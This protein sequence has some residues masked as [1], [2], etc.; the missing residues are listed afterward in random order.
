MSSYLKNHHQLIRTA[1]D[2]FDHDFFRENRIIFGGGTRIALELNEYRESIDIDFLCP[3]KQSFRAVRLE[4]SEKSLGKLVKEDFY[5]PREIRADRD[6]VRCF[7][8]ISDIPIKLEF[9]SFADYNLQIDPNNPFK[10]P[11]LSRSSCYLTKL[12]ANADR[13]ANPPYKDIFDILAMFSHWGKIPDDAWDEADTHYG[14][15]LVFRN[16]KKSCEHISNNLSAYMKIATDQLDINQD[17]AERILNISNQD[18][19]N[20][21]S[22][23]ENQL[24]N[25]SNSKRTLL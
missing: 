2:N 8:E 24:L 14:K 19:L 15:A 13:Y 9:V 18:F 20:Y 5:Y 23:I 21:L 12:L 22:D 17:Y 11:A 10:V 1:L 25:S 16:L 7:I 6:A 4:T 3:D